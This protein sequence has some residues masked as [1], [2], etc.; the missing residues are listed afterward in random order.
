MFP[1]QSLLA[2]GQQ[3]GRITPTL[4]SFHMLLLLHYLF[5]NVCAQSE[6]KEHHSRFMKQVLGVGRL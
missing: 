3:G 6:H 4:V 5:L 2:L 1:D